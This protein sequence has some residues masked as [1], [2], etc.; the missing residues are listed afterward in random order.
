[1]LPS[2]RSFPKVTSQKFIKPDTP[3]LHK[4]STPVPNILFSSFLLLHSQ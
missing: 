1:M 3:D 4:V 2:Y